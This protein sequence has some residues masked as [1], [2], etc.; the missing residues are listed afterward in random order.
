MRD[1]MSEILKLIRVRQWHKNGFVLLGFFLSGRYGDLHL[2]IKS[3]VMTGAFCFASSSVYIFND[4]RDVDSDRK[5]PVK[6]ERPLAKGT[7]GTREALSISALFLLIGLG[8]SFFVGRLGLLFVLAYLVNNLLYS[9]F[10]KAYPLIDVFLIA[11]G[12]MLRIFA[13]TIGVGIYLSE[14]M[15]I[16]G[17]MIS[18]LISFSKRYSEFTRLAMAK[19]HRP[20]LGHYSEELLRSFIIIMAASTIVTYALYTLSPRSV[21]LH[22]TTNLIYSTPIV[23]FGIFRFLHLVMV[24]GG[25]EDPTSAVLKDKWLAA[26]FLLWVVSYLLVIAFRTHSVGLG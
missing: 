1:R 2:L 4:Y 23:I 10:L 7:V 25:G 6:R 11:F 8:L 12:F 18:L 17:F 19:E 24:Q 3:A 14:W 15:V 16:T 26:T 20:V 21:E 22:G 5:H 9:I 13:G